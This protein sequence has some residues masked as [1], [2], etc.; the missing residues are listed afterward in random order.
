MDSYP[1]FC[2]LRWKC[3]VPIDKELDADSITEL[4]IDSESSLL[5]Y[6]NTY[7]DIVEQL[8]GRIPNIKYMN[9]KDIPQCI[10]KGMQLF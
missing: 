6:S 2:Y 3:D 7:A 1:F 4:L 8:Q 5:V 10:E 9:M